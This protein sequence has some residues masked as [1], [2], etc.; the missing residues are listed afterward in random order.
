MKPAL[1]LAVMLAGCTSTA[2]PFITRIQ[3]V[4]NGNLGVE[5]CYVEFTSFV[6]SI[7]TGQCVQYVVH[8]RDGEYRAPMA[9]P[10][11]ARPPGEVRPPGDVRPSP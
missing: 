10:P 6:N 3:N 11:Q 8:V 1:L 9:L 2:G 5:S 4:G 7:E